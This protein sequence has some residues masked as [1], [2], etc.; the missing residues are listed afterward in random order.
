[1]GRP[2]DVRR[3]VWRRKRALSA[4]CSRNARRILQT[5]SSV[6]LKALRL[7]LFE[8]TVSPLQI[9]KIPNFWGRAQIVESLDKLPGVSVRD[10]FVPPAKVKGSPDVRRIHS[11]SFAFVDMA[12]QEGAAAAV[13]ASVSSHSS[14]SPLSQC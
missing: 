2:F 3:L 4:L 14:S 1:M 6:V 10:V 11:R 9:A 12:D 8:L 13:K 5:A 7:L